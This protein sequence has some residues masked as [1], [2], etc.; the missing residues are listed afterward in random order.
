M[1]KMFYPMELIDKILM[2]EWRKDGQYVNRYC[3]ESLK[4]SRNQYC[5]KNKLK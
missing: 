1:I 2:K 4:S 3:Y 5:G